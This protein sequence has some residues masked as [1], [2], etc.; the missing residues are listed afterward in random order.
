MDYAKEGH[1]DDQLIKAGI[2]E[3]KRHVL[4][5]KEELSTYTFH[6]KMQTEDMSAYF[7]ANDSDII[8]KFMEQDAGFNARR[9]GFYELL[10]TTA[11]VTKKKFSDALI[12]AL[13]TIQYK[14]Y[15]RWPC[16]R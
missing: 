15:T 13:F 11:A 7:P 12:K 8:N 3:L 5:I 10:K 2:A 14:S 4:E 16:A 1:S 9:N 6:M